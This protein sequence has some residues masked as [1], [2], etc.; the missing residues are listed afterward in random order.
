MLLASTDTSS[1]DFIPPRVE[2]RTANSIITK[3]DATGPMIA[4]LFAPQISIATSTTQIISSTVSLGGQT[5]RHRW[6]HGGGLLT[7]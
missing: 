3:K 2:A 6:R 1:A 7:T 4:P 5:W